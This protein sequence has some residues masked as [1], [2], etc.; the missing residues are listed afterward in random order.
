VEPS[1]TPPDKA[2]ALVRVR[3]ALA[4][5]APAIRSVAL[6]AWRLTYQNRLPPEAIEAFLARGYTSERVAL[7]IR[8][9][10]VLVAGRAP[11]DVAEPAPVEAFAELAVHH[12]HVQ[13][14]ALYVLP[15][16]RGAKL[17]SALLDAVRAAFPG[18]DLAADVL[19]GNDLAEPFY[20]KRGFVPLE[21]LTEE[22]AGAP[23]RLRRWWLRA[24]G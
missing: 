4:A 14:V 9:H 6:A 16:L 15:G 3:D 5:D 2:L 13:L 1:R 22:I 17:G 12:D 10:R 8:R 21:E 7:R 23:V 24:P 19:E 18:R 20:A 11:D